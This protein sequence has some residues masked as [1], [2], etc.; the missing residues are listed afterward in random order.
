M[1]R[2]LYRIPLGSD[3]SDWLVA[4]VRNALASSDALDHLAVLHLATPDRRASQLRGRVFD[5]G[6]GVHYPAGSPERIARQLLAEFEPRLRMRTQ[7]ERDFDFF[8]ALTETLAQRNDRRRP[9]RPLVNELLIAWK[10]LAQALPP[11]QRTPERLAALTAPLG[12]RMP[13]LLGVMEHYRKRLAATG[14]ADP[15]DALWEVAQRM[16]RWNFAPALVLVDDLD[17]V[18][19]AR[20][21]FLEALA[22]RTGR[23]LFLLRGS[24]DDLPFLEQAHDVQQALVLDAGGKVAATPGLPLLRGANVLEAW[25]ADAAT[26]GIDVICPATRAAEVREAARFVRRAMNDGTLPSALCVAMPS[27]GAYADL[28]SETFAAAGIPYDAPFEATLDQAT[29]VAAI[30]D[31]L[32]AAHDGL[33]RTALMD[34]LASPYLA[35]GQSVPRESLEKVQAATIEGWVV[36]GRNAQ[37]DWLDKLKPHC[38]AGALSWLQSVLSLL[39]PFTRGGGHAADLAAAVTELLRKSGAA[40]IAHSD[41]AGGSVH[42]ATRALAL[43]EFGHLLSE[44]Q[45]EFKR[46]GNP[47]LRVSDF[48]RALGEQALARS[49]RPPQARGERVRVLGLRE[50]RGARFEQVI[51]LGLTDIDLPLSDEDSMF[52]PAARQELLAHTAGAAMASELCAPIDTARQADYLFAHAL[53]SASKRLVLSLPQA[54]GDTP[55]VPATPLARLKRCV[56]LDKLPAALGPELPTSDHELARQAARQLARAESGTAPGHALALDDALKTGLHGRA[57]ELA[58]SDMVAAPTEYDGAVIALPGL[59][60]SFSATA[61]ELRHSF[62][63]SQMDNYVE[64]PQRF[65]SRYVMRA[66]PP[67]EPTLDTPPHAIGTLLHTTFERYVLLLRREAGQPDVLPDPVTRKPVHLLD[68]AADENAAREAGYRLI[69]EAFA[70]ACVIE[71]TQGPFWEGVKRQVRAGLPGEPQ[72]GL[73]RGLL[74][75]FIDEEIARAQQGIG[76]RFVEFDFG[77]GNPPAPDS[78]DAV[79]QPIDLPLETGMIRL[80]GSVD[81]VDEGPD[82]LEIVDYKTGGAKST[83]EVRDGEAF[84]L[85]TYLAAIA[86]LTGSKPRGMSYL[87]VPAQ[88]KVERKDVTL[89]NKKPAFEVTRLVD[90]VLPQRLSRM[91]NALSTGVFVHLPFASPG[92]PCRYC[93]YA[94]SCA[95]R[96]DVIE[97]RQ[98]RQDGTPGAYLPDAELAE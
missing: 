43:H 8:A 17:R 53:I 94:G 64:C 16:P 82:G 19:P 78:P 56:G 54:Q 66:K 60:Q 81:R 41:A 23:C 46:I 11:G 76:V 67:D 2:E 31:L 61:G 34:A 14:C 7:V 6:F 37:R 88:K 48:L 79:P 70:Q 29:P 39:A 96:D 93:D 47:S 28:I 80:M 36:G 42:A 63:P 69:G 33:D 87:L 15:E 5:G 85:A 12:E 50:L 45:A 30:L 59:Q 51:V 65:W 74:A 62:S 27:T 38:D 84:Q 75:R 86:K 83:A 49:V 97:E 20:A 71:K 52:L 73:G 1:G 32:R 18:S 55:F 72:A 26:T 25:H 89:L 44:M 10:R 35:F 90:E 95:R 4:Q 13:V 9:G 40:A 68:V 77:K 24:R 57:I 98:Q 92:A 3:D 91:M 58:R 22:S 21:A